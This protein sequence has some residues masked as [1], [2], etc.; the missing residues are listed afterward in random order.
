[1]TKEV[2]DGFVK[3]QLQDAALIQGQMDNG[4]DETAHH[5][6]GDAAP[7]QEVHP[8]DQKAAQ[9]EQQHGKTGGLEHIKGECG[10]RIDSFSVQICERGTESCR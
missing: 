9:H 2:F 3:G 6:G 8:G 7:A 5:R 4:E 1:L 10:H